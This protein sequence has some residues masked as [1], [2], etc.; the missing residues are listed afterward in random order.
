MGLVGASSSYQ[1]LSH[2]RGDRTALNQLDEHLFDT[3]HP[4]LRLQV[5][6]QRAYL[7]G[8]GHIHDRAFP[9]AVAT[10]LLQG[11]LV[12]AAGALIAGRRNGRR[13][14]LQALAANAVIVIASYA[15]LAPARS[16][17]LGVFEAKA[18]AIR[19][20]PS[21]PERPPDEALSFIVQNQ[22]IQEMG[23]AGAEVGFYLLAAL[24][25]YRRRAKIYFAALE[26]D[27]AVE[28]E[29]P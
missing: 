23:R 15:A 20:L 17:A 29:G 28:P 6:Y 13:L 2:L 9:I 22:P 27:A 18:E 7:V 25:L 21:S 1:E 26:E 11:L 5:E 14:M 12:W 24:A 3:S 16:E 10:L 19:N 8:L 4:V